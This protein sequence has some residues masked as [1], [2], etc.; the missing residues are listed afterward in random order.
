MDIKKGS[1]WKA[2]YDDEKGRY[3]AEYGGGANYDLYEIDR[4][5]FDKLDKRMKGREASDIISSGR[6][7]YMSVN[8]RCGPPYTVVFDDDYNELCPWASVSDS[9]A[10]VFPKAMTDAAVELFASEEKNREHRRNKQNN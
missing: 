5:L 6:H 9:D 7:M 8:D 1:C 4:E 3:F 10:Q 2:V